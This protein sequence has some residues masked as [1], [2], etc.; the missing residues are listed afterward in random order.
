M[1]LELQSSLEFVRALGLQH[2]LHLL[3]MLKELEEEPHRVLSCRRDLRVEHALRLLTAAKHE[4]IDDELRSRAAINWQDT[5]S[6]VHG[7]FVYLLQSFQCYWACRELQP[8]QHITQLGL[9]FNLMGVHA[10]RASE[11]RDGRPRLAE[12]RYVAEV[13]RTLEI[14]RH[15]RAVHCS[16]AGAL[17]E[18]AGCLAEYPA[19]ASQRTRALA[20]R[21]DGDTQA[22]AAPQ[23]PSELASAALRSVPMDKAALPGHQRMFVCVLRLVAEA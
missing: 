2:I 8:L 9:G 19:R 17:Q 15:R 20:G 10:H 1:P 12:V 23:S 11:V 21:V 22:G 13:G 3:R 5:A 6:F 18:N 16:E 4:H 14:Q 7:G